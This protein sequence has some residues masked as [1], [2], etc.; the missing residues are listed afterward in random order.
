MR[1]RLEA[2]IALTETAQCRTRA[3]LA[4]FGEELGGACGHCDNCATRSALFDGTVEAQKVLSAVYRT[5]QMFGATAHR[6][7]A[8]RREQPRRW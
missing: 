8:A 5:G 4:C 7:R 1:A 6:R 2:M 3:L